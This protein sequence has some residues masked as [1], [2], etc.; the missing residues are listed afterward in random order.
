MYIARALAYLIVSN[1]PGREG[2]GESELDIRTEWIWEVMRRD[3]ELGVEVLGE[4]RGKNG[5]LV[6]EAEDA[7]KCEYHWDGEGEVCPLAK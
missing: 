6:G 3:E 2:G 1:A 4:L 7:E 5:V